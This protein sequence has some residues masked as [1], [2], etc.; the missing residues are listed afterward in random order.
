MKKDSIAMLGEQYIIKLMPMEGQALSIA[1]MCD[2]FS[3]NVNAFRILDMM[4]GG[5]LDA[6]VMFIRRDYNFMLNPSLVTPIIMIFSFGKER[7]KHNLSALKQVFKGVKGLDVIP[8]YSKKI[9]TL[10]YVS[11]G[12]SLEKE[13]LSTRLSDLNKRKVYQQK[14][15]F[16]SGYSL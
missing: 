13:R 4:T 3:V 16:Y 2:L 5:E 10:L 1:N 7:T 14:L 6:D 12:D 8:A 9:N 15:Y 11:S